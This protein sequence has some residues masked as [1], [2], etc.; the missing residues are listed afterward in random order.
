MTDLIGIYSISDIW[1]F[2]LVRSAAPDRAWSRWPDMKCPQPVSTTSHCPWYPL[3]D[4]VWMQIIS[5]PLSSQGP[6][7]QDPFQTS[8]WLLGHHPVLWLADWTL[9]E[10][11]HSGSDHWLSLVSLGVPPGQVS[12]VGSVSC[13]HE[14]DTWQC[15]DHVMSNAPVTCHTCH[16]PSRVSDN[17][18][19]ASVP[20]SLSPMFQVLIISWQQ[21]DRDHSCVTTGVTWV[22]WHSSQDVTKTLAA[23]QCNRYSHCIRVHQMLSS[24]W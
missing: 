13:C 16:V 18:T 14:R 4:L 11:C 15:H 23:L 5:W 8:D 3:S 2:S 19:I 1:Y 22:S 17:M 7:S 20:G 24:L 10:S 6:V 9:L 12:R 21:E